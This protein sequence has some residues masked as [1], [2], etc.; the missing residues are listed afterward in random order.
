LCC[1]NDLVGEPD[2]LARLYGIDYSVFQSAGFPNELNLAN[3]ILLWQTQYAGGEEYAP[4]RRDGTPGK[5][6]RRQIRIEPTLVRVDIPHLVSE[7]VFQRAQEII[8]QRALTSRKSKERNVG[9]QRFLVNG[10]LRCACGELIYNRYGGRGTHSD[11]YY[12][13]SSARGGQRCGLCSIRRDTLDRVIVRLATEQLLDL[14]FLRT[15]L[16]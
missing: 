11:S 2:Q 7:E 1:K 8:A 5:K 6:R 10:L 12:C 16:V 9:R 14:T 13:S 3:D 4:M 15:L